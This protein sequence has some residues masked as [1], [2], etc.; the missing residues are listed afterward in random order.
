M[1]VKNNFK[2]KKWYTDYVYSCSTENLLFREGTGTTFV[3][4]IIEIQGSND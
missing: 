4:N 1:Y 3:V 2:L